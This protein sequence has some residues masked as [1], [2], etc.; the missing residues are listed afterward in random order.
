MNFVNI[1][2]T[3]FS[4]EFH[5][6]VEVYVEYIT[7]NVLCKSTTRDEE[8]YEVHHILPRS[9]FPEYE[10][11]PLNLVKLK[12]YD[13]FV[14]HY[15]IAKTKNPK[16]VYAFNMMN[17][18]KTGFTDDQ[19]EQA[20]M[21][22]ADFREELSRIISKTNTGKTRTPGHK[23]IIGKLTKG[24]IAVKQNATGITKRIPVEEYHANPHLYTHHAT[25][26]IHKES[27]KQLMSDNGIKGKTAF[28][29]RVTLDV[30]FEDESFS[31]PDYTKGNLV[32]SSVASERFKGDSHWTHTATGESVRA[33]ECPGPGWIKKR[34]NFENPFATQITVFDIRTGEKS[35]IQKTD[36]ELH[37]VVHNAVIVHNDKIIAISP[38]EK[39][40]LIKSGDFTK[41]SRKDFMY[42]SQCIK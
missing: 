31:H 26:R 36:R 15:L 25:G 24:M 14:A 38:I 41:T 13:H 40:K 9:L 35:F 8:Q 16:M 19:L 30:I 42:K 17:R 12:L 39:K 27:T 3:Y 21:M 2:K 20:A 6:D 18:V 33:K 34:S 10:F 4:P 23:E 32:Q 11:E 37:H 29:H 1:L 22:Y 28:T 5:K 7:S